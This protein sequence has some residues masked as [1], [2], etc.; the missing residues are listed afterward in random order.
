[1]KFF[2]Y[3]FKKTLLSPSTYITLI[4]TLVI[5]WIIIFTD[6]AEAYLPI[7]I[8]F[9]LPIFIIFITYTTAKIFRDEVENQTMLS[10]L[11]KPIKRSNL[12]FEGFLVIVTW[13]FIGSL[14]ISLLPGLVVAIRE[15]VSYLRPFLITVSLFILGSLFGSIALML[16]LLMKGKAFIGVM[17][18]AFGSGFYLLFGLSSFLQIRYDQNIDVN[19]ILLN[20]NYQ[21]IRVIQQKQNDNLIF[22]AIDPNNQNPQD[23][24]EVYNGIKSL[25][26]RKPYSVIKWFDPSLH[27]QSMFGG[28]NSVGKVDQ[29]TESTLLSRGFEGTKVKIF[30]LTNIKNN[31][32]TF[33]AKKEKIIPLW[34]PYVIW[35]SIGSALIFLSLKKINKINIT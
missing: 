28:Y 27:W 17:L 25:T 13:I 9:T 6:I 26:E 2:S 10:I 15:K 33:E 4:L 22:T 32:F 11:S 16:S 3:T 5:P 7:L 34:Y 29:N 19:S 12:I 30:N 23:L 1:M 14:L 31:Q 24:Q 8:Y 18:G 20:A 21:N 35:L